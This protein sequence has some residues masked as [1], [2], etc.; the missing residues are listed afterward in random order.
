MQTAHRRQIAVHHDFREIGAEDIGA[1]F[2]QN[3]SQSNRDLPLVGTQVG[4]QP[5][6][7][8]AVIRFT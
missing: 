5:F 1:G 8:P 6:H 2:D 7:Q 4:E 3:R